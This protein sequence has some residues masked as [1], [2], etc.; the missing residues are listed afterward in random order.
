MLSVACVS[1]ASAA[2]GLNGLHQPKSSAETAVELVSGSRC[3]TRS[4][5][6]SRRKAARGVEVHH[7]KKRRSHASRHHSHRHRVHSARDSSDAPRGCLTSAARG[8]LSRIEG[9]FGRVTV[10]STCRPG[11]RIAGTNRISRH[12]SGNA[13]DFDA[14]GRKSQIVSWLIANHRSGGTMT[15]PDMNHI[16]VD[17]GPHFVSIAG[18]RHYASWSG[19]TSSHRSHREAKA[20]THRRIAIKRGPSMA[21]ARMDVDGDD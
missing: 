17:I 6:A 3:H 15:Y 20:H 14:G 8:L 5:K 4:C 7:R 11:A 10:I 13:V 9:R 19:K 12:A 16:H 2:P 1:V 18:G 21:R